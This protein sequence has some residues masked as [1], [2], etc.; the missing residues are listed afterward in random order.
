MW[1]KPQLFKE[2]LACFYRRVCRLLEFAVHIWMQ[3]R[4]LDF[5]W[6]LCEQLL[7]LTWKL[8]YFPCLTIVFVWVICIPETR[9]ATLDIFPLLNMIMCIYYLEVWSGNS[10]F[11]LHTSWSWS[12]TMT[13]RPHT[14]KYSVLWGICVVRHCLGYYCYEPLETRGKKI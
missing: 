1:W 12:V 9:C 7:L 5:P 4:M 2:T 14:T 3:I 6:V 10:W 8:F 13:N 11:V